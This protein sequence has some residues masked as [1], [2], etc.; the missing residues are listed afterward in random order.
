MRSALLSHRESKH[1]ADITARKDY[2]PEMI[3]QEQPY[4]PQLE[5]RSQ[6]LPGL[7]TTLRFT[8]K[9]A[10][11]QDRILGYGDNPPQGPAKSHLMAYWNNYTRMRGYK[12]STGSWVP[13]SCLSP[14][15][16]SEMDLSWISLAICFRGGSSSTIMT[17][18]LHPQ[19]RR[20]TGFHKGKEEK[21]Q[22]QILTAAH[23]R[24]P[25]L[26]AFLICALSFLFLC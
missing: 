19:E 15:V 18:A 8:D 21:H 7:A 24:W 23:H 11:Q 9:R 17:N 10:L 14:T 4:C 6:P 3:V 16:A 13:L 22:V 1:W 2:Q 20:P 12:N 25:C 5:R 26:H